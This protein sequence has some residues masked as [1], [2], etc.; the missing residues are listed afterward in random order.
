M[1]SHCKIRISIRHFHNLFS[2]RVQFDRFTC[3]LFRT[4][5]NILHIVMSSK[6]MPNGRSIPVTE[7]YV[8]VFHSFSATRKR[9]ML[10]VRVNYAIVLPPLPPPFA[11]NF[12]ILDHLIWARWRYA[13]NGCVD[14]GA[15]SC[16]QRTAFVA[17][18]TTTAVQQ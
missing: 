4:R 14:S 1:F 13:F 6:P 5:E 2:L 11:N 7:V 12:A 18:T 8:T 16:V 9:G 15:S 3:T 17:A 10:W